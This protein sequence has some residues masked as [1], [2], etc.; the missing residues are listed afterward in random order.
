MGSFVYISYSVQ[1]NQHQGNSGSYIYITGLI[2]YY[3]SV[4]MWSMLWLD[5]VLL[6]LLPTKVT[7]KYISHKG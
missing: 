1:I 5:S 3:M 6:C 7:L 4:A 2:F